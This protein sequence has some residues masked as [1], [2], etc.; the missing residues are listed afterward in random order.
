MIEN[1][2]ENTKDAVRDVIRIIDCLMFMIMLNVA[3]FGC[4]MHFSTGKLSI[5]MPKQ[6]QEIAHADNNQP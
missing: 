1:S 2:D 4:A 3:V 5:E 6:K